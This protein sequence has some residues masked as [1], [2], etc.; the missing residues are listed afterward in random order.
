MAGGSVPP[1][2]DSKGRN[3]EEPSAAAG[4]S[5]LC[6]ARERGNKL[7]KLGQFEKAIEAYSEALLAADGDQRAEMPLLANRALAAL[8]LGNFAEALEDSDRVLL[9]EPEHRKALFRRGQA[10]AALGRHQE[11]EE[12]LDQLR[13][14]EPSNEE[15]QAEL[16]RAKVAAAQAA[17]GDFDFRV[18]LAEAALKETLRLCHS[19]PEADFQSD[20]LELID[21]ES[22]RGRA[23][24]ARRQIEAGE[25]LLAARPLVFAT[26]AEF[27]AG[28]HQIL[29][30]KVLEAANKDKSSAAR[31]GELCGARDAEPP[32]AGQVCEE[33]A[34]DI[35]RRNCVA[36]TTGVGLWRTQSFLNHA[37]K[38][39]ATRSFIADWSLVHAKKDIPADSE[40]TLSYIDACAEYE[41]QASWLESLGV[42]DDALKERSRRWSESAE[43]H[44]LAIK[45]QFT[46]VG[47]ASTL[48]PPEAAEE[49]ALSEQARYLDLLHSGKAEIWCWGQLVRWLRDRKVL[50]R[51]HGHVQRALGASLA[52]A[53]LVER[54]TGEGAMALEAWADC[55]AMLF[56]L[57]EAANEEQGQVM[58]R[59][60]DGVQ[61]STEFLFGTRWVDDT[62]FSTLVLEWATLRHYHA[63]AWQQQM[64]G[65]NLQPA[66]EAAA[67]DAALD[68]MD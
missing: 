6:L 5:K 37:D 62:D 38:P 34:R 53:E 45:A 28:N 19:L 55:A 21:I 61:R 46:Q 3:G 63:F 29:V 42:C 68:D 44:I 39:N 67:S 10:L 27:S 30:D 23:W 26:Y 41:V 50:D 48:W 22:C 56:E 58:E 4:S 35:L 15:V 9:L 47:S 59:C 13:T 65:Q 18:M 11:A 7:V 43:P 8:R 33:T 51:E 49:G 25:L 52:I 54:H 64:T 36:C 40:V 17:R 60:I 31:L 20:A 2:A 12:A 57:P 14:L 1:T 16:R 66:P 32:L 24:H